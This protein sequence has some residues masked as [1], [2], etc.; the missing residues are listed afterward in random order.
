M[1][2]G[3]QITTAREAF[4][5]AAVQPCLGLEKVLVQYEAWEAA[6][7]GNTHSVAE[8]REK[9][10]VARRVARER[11][12]LGEG[13]SL[14]QM[15]TA[16]KGTEGALLAKWRRLWQFESNNQ[17]R[18]P[19]AQLQARMAFTFKQL[20][21]V[22]WLMPQAWHEAAGWMA[23]HKHLDAA[24]ALYERSLEVL[25]GSDLLLLAFARFEE[26]VDN[27]SAA[28]VCHPL[29]TTHQPPLAA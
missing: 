25:P 20:L 10:S 17:Q 15:P 11:T 22:C 29:P 24:R 7:G 14:D 27:L 21:M 1:Q 16:E 12:R 9:E 2:Q 5:R 4:Q 23:S 6:V 26:S 3:M 19:D 13:L 28:Q 18:L 8:L